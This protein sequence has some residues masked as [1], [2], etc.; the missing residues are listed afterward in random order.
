M[1]EQ[2]KTSEMKHTPGPWHWGWWRHITAEG[3][4]TGGS[5]FRPES[6][7]ESF[8]EEGLVLASCEYGHRS[9]NPA[10]TESL[11]VLDSM[12]TGCGGETSV[13]GGDADMAL[14]EATP[15]LLAACE[16]V[17]DDANNPSADAANDGIDWCRVSMKTIAK[18]LAVIAKA[19]S[20]G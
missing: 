13:F 16:G 7:L 17:A 15:D 12:A 1:T 2:P 14:I 18:V 20:K 4:W 3:K 6:E 8:M 10:E 5:E 11:T 19:K 9:K